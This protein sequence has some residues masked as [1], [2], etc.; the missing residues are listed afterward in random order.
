MIQDIAPKKYDNHY[1]EQEPSPEDWML[2]YHKGDV[3]CRFENGNLTFPKAEEI[4]QEEQ[5]VT[6]L[7][8]ISSE[9]FFLLKNDLTTEL[10]GY[11]WERPAI[12]REA[13]PR[14]RSFAGITGQQLDSWYRSN[15]FCGCCGHPMVPDHK[16]RMV[17]CEA[18]GNMVYPKI[19]PGIITAVTD[20]NRL[21]LTKYAHRP[22][23]VN[24]ALV[25][26]FTEIGETLEETVQ[27]EV[28]EEVGLKVKNIRYYKSQP[29]A[30]SSTLLCGFF[31]DVDGGRDITL[32]TEEL[33]VGEWFEREDIPIDDDGVSLTREMIGLFKAGKEPR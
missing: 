24:Y 9:K 20:G 3:L 33:A 11:S 1:E 7:F 14:Y 18:C 32:D 19:C 23:S 5:E 21:L 31:C 15:Q 30:F 29:W 10:P 17:R 28:M 26:G 16:E 12:F 4:T 25:A 8:T 22:G 6:Y 13:R 2:V 27:R